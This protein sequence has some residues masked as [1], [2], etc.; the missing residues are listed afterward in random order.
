MY[1]ILDDVEVNLHVEDRIISCQFAKGVIDKPSEDEMR[2]IEQVLMPQ[3]LAKFT[4][5]MAAAILA[6]AP[7]E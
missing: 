5:S 7:K 6:P 3:G 1:E 2:V 4:K